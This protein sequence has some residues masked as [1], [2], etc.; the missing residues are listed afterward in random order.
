MI[1]CGISEYLT[2]PDSDTA[3][4][5]IVNIKPD[6][7]LFVLEKEEVALRQFFQVVRARDFAGNRYLPLI[8][9]A[10]R[11]S[12]A[13][14]KLAIELGASE[15]V[16]LPSSTEALS[17]AIYRA[18]FVGR[19]FIDVPTY[20]GPCRRRKQA[21]FFGKEKRKLVWDYSASPVDQTG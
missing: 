12:M 6:A 9:A 8:V 11:P 20:F 13:L 19:P 3:I 15:I 10:W 17:R 14:I 16:S 5:R 7:A 1:A 21:T 18:V 2:C 4:D